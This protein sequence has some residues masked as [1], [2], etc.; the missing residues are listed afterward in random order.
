MILNG[1]TVD[2]EALEIEL[3]AAGIP[4]RALGTLGD[5]IFTYDEQG[6]PV[7]LPPGAAAVIEAHELPEPPL[8]KNDLLLMMLDGLEPGDEASE[9]ILMV[10][11]EMLR[12]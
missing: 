12:P 7:D 9:I 1:K 10:Q 3:N 6:M 4:T 8:T 11:Q 2:L 5:E